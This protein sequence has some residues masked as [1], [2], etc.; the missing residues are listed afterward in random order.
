VIE[1]AAIIADVLQGNREAFA[2]LV[3]RYSGK[4]LGLCMTLVH[5]RAEAEDAAQEA[6]LKAY[7]SLKDFRG[8]AAFL[9]W[10]YRIAY[11]QCLTLRSQ[12]ARRKS[13]LEKVKEDTHAASLPLAGDSLVE[14]TESALAI[15]EV[16]PNDY[17]QVIVLR[18]DGFHYQEIAEMMGVS[19]DAVKAKLRRARRSVAEKIDLSQRKSRNAQGRLP[20][21]SLGPTRQ[22]GDS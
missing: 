7:K 8:E 12:S 11:N 19:V 14:K 2:L 6:F 21:D 22:E 10:L 5:D 20:V 18:L 16:L 17:R 9:T 4:I 3:R 13:Q 1:D 15:L